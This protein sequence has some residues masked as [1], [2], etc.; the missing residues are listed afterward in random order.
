[1]THEEHWDFERNGHELTMVA[2]YLFHRPFRMPGLQA[3][4]ICELKILDLGE[5]SPHCGRGSLENMPT[6]SST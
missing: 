2:K 3:G 1:M 4:I 5:V 6:Q